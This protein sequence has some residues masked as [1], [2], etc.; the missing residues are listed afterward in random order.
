M[1]KEKLTWQQLRSELGLLAYAGFFGGVPFG[2][3]VYI[4]WN[5]AHG[6]LQLIAGA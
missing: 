3:G 1:D 4:G 6:L 2:A 5:A